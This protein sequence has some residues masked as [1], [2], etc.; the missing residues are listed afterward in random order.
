MVI[1]FM[2]LMSWQHVVTCQRVGAVLHQS[3]AS[4]PVAW[5]STEWKHPQALDACGVP[6]IKHLAIALFRHLRQ[7]MPEG[8][9]LPIKD[10]LGCLGMA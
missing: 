1:G 4:R 7:A 8:P 2:L 9:Q 10:L 5:A 3:R 6:I